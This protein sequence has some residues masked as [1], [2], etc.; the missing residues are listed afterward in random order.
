MIKNIYS[1]CGLRIRLEQERRRMWSQKGLYHQAWWHMLCTW[2][3]EVG[4]EALCGLG[5]RLA[6]A[7]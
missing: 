3:A 4:T 7:T 1:S 2:E 5:S 6:S